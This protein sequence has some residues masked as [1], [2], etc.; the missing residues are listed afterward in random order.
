MTGYG[1]AT[2]TYDERT[3]TIELRSV[4]SKS[5][6]LR[7]K[8]PIDFKEKEILLRRIIN[9]KI[10]RGKLDLII[11]IEDNTNNSRGINHLLFK[12]YYHEIQALQKEL[13]VHSTKDYIETIL[14][15]PNVVTGDTD[16]ISDELWEQIESVL[17]MAFNH[18]NEHRKEEGFSIKIDI[19]TRIESILVL[20][21]K[22]HPFEKERVEKVKQRLRSSMEEFWGRDSVD[23]NRFEQ[24]LIYYLEKMD[25]SEEKQRLEQHCTYFLEILND[26]SLSKGRQ[27]SFISQEIG[28]EINTLGAKAYHYEIQKLIVCMKDELEKVKEQLANIL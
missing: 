14:R 2:K 5:T 24:E 7:F 8:L 11:S 15:I 22:I 12:K 26:R 20:L 18:L 16:G 9:E 17:N 1:R 19:S 13:D 3:I 21:N 25:F 23:E 28:R 4:N 6:D 27:L 10:E